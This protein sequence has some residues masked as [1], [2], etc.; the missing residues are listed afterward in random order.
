M[1]SSC[2]QRPHLKPHH[3]A[4]QLADR[5]VQTPGVAAGLRF[6]GEVASLEHQRVNQDS[7]HASTVDLVVA[8]LNNFPKILDA[9]G[10]LATDEA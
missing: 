3:T 5:H 9:N 7:S 6:G 8:P 1:K 2:Q 4:A 10:Q